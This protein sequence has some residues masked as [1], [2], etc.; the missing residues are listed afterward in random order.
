MGAQFWRARL[1]KNQSGGRL[2]TA[3]ARK[4]DTKRFRRRF[5]THFFGPGLVFRRFW[6]PGRTPKLPKNRPW[7]TPG[8][9]FDYTFWIFSRFV[10]SGVFQKGPGPILRAL[11]TLPDQILGRFRDNFWLVPP[12]SCRGLSGSAGMLPGCTPTLR[13][14]LCGV[15]PGVQRSRAAM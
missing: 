2:R 4:N 1:S 15:P 7:E 8:V 14:S 12:G 5:R 10:R 6:A 13:N 3:P 11:G 9:F